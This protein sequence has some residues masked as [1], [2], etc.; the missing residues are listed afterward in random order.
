MRDSISDPSIKTLSCSPIIVKS[1]L[2]QYWMFETYYNQ[3]TWAREVFVT[4]LDIVFL[5]FIIFRNVRNIC[6]VRSVR[7]TRRLYYNFSNSKL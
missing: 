5:N 4:R 1:T 7:N 3:L 6:I 2:L